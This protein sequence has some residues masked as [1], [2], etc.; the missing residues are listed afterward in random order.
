MRTVGVSHARVEIVTSRLASTNGDDEAGDGLG[1]RRVAITSF[2]ADSLHGRAV[3]RGARLVPRDVA[4]R[5]RSGRLNVP[6]ASGGPPPHRIE[7]ACTTRPSSPGRASRCGVGGVLDGGVERRVVRRPT[8]ATCI[9]SRRARRGEIVDAS[10]REWLALVRTCVVHTHVV[11]VP[12]PRIVE[13][14]DEEAAAASRVGDRMRAGM[15][16][17][18]RGAAIRIDA[19]RCHVA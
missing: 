17:N 13:V 1:D 2:S 4:E 19:Q 14:V 5:G 6:I 3:E 10:G 18:I 9:T 7:R 8:A 12:A 16:R 15:A 11:L